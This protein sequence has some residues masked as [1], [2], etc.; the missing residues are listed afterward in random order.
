MLKAL[1]DEYLLVTCI[2]LKKGNF[3]EY[4]MKKLS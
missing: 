2:W 3:V 1:A 4:I